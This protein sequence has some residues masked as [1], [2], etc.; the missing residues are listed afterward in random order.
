MTT[1]LAM[2]TGVDVDEEG[3]EA[4]V[5]VGVVVELMIV[6]DEHRI[7]DGLRDVGGVEVVEVE[8]LRLLSGEVGGKAKGRL[9]RTGSD[10]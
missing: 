2:G 3:Q 5:A 10:L 9:R 8:V 4:A 7:V 6:I 1:G